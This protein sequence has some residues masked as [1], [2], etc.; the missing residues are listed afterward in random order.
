M[1]SQW[2]QFV[3][4]S[5]NGT[6]LFQR[7][8]MDYHSDRFEDH[9]LMV[10]KGNSL[11]AL[12]PA[13]ISDSQ[14][15]SHQGLS[16]GG[17]V[18]SKKEKLNTTLE[19]F[20][21]VLAFL[22]KEKIEKLHLKLVPSIYHKVPSDELEYLLFITEATL[23]RVDVSSV[24][25]SASRVKIQSNRMEGVKKAEKNGLEIREEVRFDAFW[26]EILLSN[27][28]Q[29]HG[30]KPTHS[31]EEIELLAARFPKHIKQFNV[32]KKNKIVGGATIF[33]TQTACH[34]Q[35][36]SGNEE[37]QQLGSLDFL[38]EYL[39]TK[40]FNDKKY[41]DFGISNENQG[42]NINKGLL[43]WKETFGARTISNKHYTVHTNN[44]GKLDTVFL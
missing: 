7:G 42:R 31:L 22:N 25:E 28:E 38:F 27:L 43:Y 18:L 34:I 37:K 6:F 35:Y 13:N 23:T 33:E 36:I 4:N 40:R 16:Y 14:L 8:F 9:S 15:H 5:K 29:R 24:I 1:R 2:D 10:F 26:N 12:L 21:E 32:F 39:I 3:T 19:I 11:L 17:L 44:Y 30:A 41:F 20:R